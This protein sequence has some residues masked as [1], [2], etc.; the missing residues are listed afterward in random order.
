MSV[1]PYVLIADSQEP[2][3][4]ICMSLA[5]SLGYRT[6]GVASGEEVLRLLR[7]EPPDVLVAD[8]RLPDLDGVELLQRV[9]QTWPQVAVLL[10]TAYGSVGTAVEA[11]K[12]GASDYLAKPFEVEELRLLLQNSVRQVLVS[13][14]AHGQRLAAR[15][16]YAAGNLIGA[17]PEMQRVFRLIAKVAQS[18]YSVLILGESGT[19]KEVVAR[20]LH[21]TGPERDRPFLPVDCGALV[22]SLVE[23][24]LFGH[25]RG[26]FTGANQNHQGL[27]EVAQGGTVFLDEIGELPLDVQVKLLRALQEKEIR[28]VGGTRR[29]KID[30]RIVAATNRDLQAAV[31][32]G[33]FR[34]DLFFRL[35]VVSIKLPPLRE[36]SLDIAML[37]DHFLERG[38]PPG[39]A[40][41]RFSEAAMERLLAYDWPGNVRELENCV[42]RTLALAGGPRLEVEDLPSPLQHARLVRREAGVAGPVR[43]LAELEREAIFEALAHVKGDKI[44]AA[45]LLGIGKTTLYRKLKEYGQAALAAPPAAGSASVAATGGVQ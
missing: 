6:A 27:L 19:G 33:S 30:V 21:Y 7:Q 28:P 13:R 39:A 32:N 12:L 36:R 43:P 40:P 10:T 37:V 44:L 11:M 20:A 9:K 5:T 14:E 45:R 42:E 18:R 1:V 25:V 16:P 41:R 38:T 34:K 15:G 23:S 4:E 35:N 24:E 8:V 22:P 31:A 29:T 17:S 2:V 3:R 26:A